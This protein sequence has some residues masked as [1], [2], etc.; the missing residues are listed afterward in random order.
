M[1]TNRVADTT[2]MRAMPKRAARRPASRQLARFRLGTRRQ[3]AGDGQE[4]FANASTPPGLRRVLLISFCVCAL[5]LT[6]STAASAALEVTSGLTSYQ[7]LQRDAT[8]HADVEIAG[9]VTAEG[10]DSIEARIL[11]RRLVVEGF[12]WDQVGTVSGDRW[13][14]NI[15]ALPV[16]GPYQVELRAL[17]KDRQTLASATVQSVLVGDL[18]VLSGQSNM[19]GNGRLEELETPHELVH[20]FNPRDEWQVAEEPLHSLAESINEV[21]WKH[22]SHLLSLWAKPGQQPDGPLIGEDAARFRKN[23][24]HGAGLALTFSKDMVRRTGIPIGLVPCA[25]GGTSIGPGSAD[26]PGWDPALK[27]R[28]RKSLYGSMMERF[29]AVGG[30]VKGVLW[31]QGEADMREERAS[32]YAQRFRGLIEAIRTDFGQPDL[33]FYYA[34]I[35]RYVTE[36]RMHWN[37]IQEVQRLAEEAISNVGMVASVDLGLDDIIHISG[38]GLKT[39]GHRFANL[40]CHDLFPEVEACRD[41][42]RGPRPH[43]AFVTV[44]RGRLDPWGGDRRTLYVEFSDVNGRLQS[45]GRL[46]GFSIRDADETE[47]L[48]IFRAFVDPRSPNR[49]VLE[50][51]RGIPNEPL[52]PGAKLW[53]GWGSDPYC[54]LVD[55]ADMAAPV[56]GPMDIEGVPSEN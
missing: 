15:K 35:G 48:A 23:R 28:G 40:V 49:V 51:G 27:E 21:N 29:L 8:N 13:T 14:G 32:E 36:N 54:N 50:L 10:A 18:W 12:D 34:Q 9:T 5:T 7:V 42:K 3:P 43:R 53:Y 56:F 2:Q 16:G 55:D 39:A 38:E 25:H 19:V 1:M 31:Y 26:W 52:P 20:N 6:A 24:Q 11:R 46:S 44:N 33:P 30:R 47:I 41:L 37:K 22:A 4:R 45:A 17:G